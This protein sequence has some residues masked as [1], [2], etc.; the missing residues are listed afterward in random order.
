MVQ[1]ASEIYFVL[2][3]FIKTF[4]LSRSWD[5]EKPLHVTSSTGISTTKKTFINAVGKVRKLSPRSEHR[6]PTIAH[7]GLGKVFVGGLSRKDYRED[8]F[9]PMIR[10]VGKSKN[11]EKK[12]TSFP[13]GSLRMQGN[14]KKKKK[15]NR[16]FS[17]QFP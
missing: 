14:R 6:S 16:R 5:E 1:T 10:T 11:R 9:F 15:K 4:V 17:R 13:S 2:H 8:I 7:G 12:K 3:L